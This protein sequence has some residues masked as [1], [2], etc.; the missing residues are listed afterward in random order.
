MHR[1][2]TGEYVLLRLR[3]K[4]IT[5]A[6]IQ[7][8]LYELE[9]IAKAYL[10]DDIA[11]RRFIDSPYR[12]SPDMQCYICNT[13]FAKN[14]IGSVVDRVTCQICM[15]QVCARKCSVSAV[16]MAIHSAQ[17]RPYPTAQTCQGCFRFI[18]ALNSRYARWT[19]CAS[20][21]K[22]LAD[23]YLEVSDKMTS[24]SQKLANFEGLALMLHAEPS[25][26]QTIRGMVEETES[27]AR[28]DLD[29]LQSLAS[30]IRG[31]NCPPLPH[32]DS[33]LRDSLHRYVQ[34]TLSNLKLKLGQAAQ[35]SIKRPKH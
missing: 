6:V 11:I 5:S 1:D 31:L 15:Q 26:D 20:S 3:R 2:L 25:L 23:L 34:E 16:F 12:G 10:Y 21:S 9:M 28:K 13:V 22:A 14:F 24:A 19:L 18:K 7:D 30:S 33:V 8:R 4:P 35:M 17:V 32:Q 29:L 27:L